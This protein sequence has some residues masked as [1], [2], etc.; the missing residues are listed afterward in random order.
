[1]RTVAWVYFGPVIA[2]GALMLFVF[3][4]AV[5]AVAAQLVGVMLKHARL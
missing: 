3:G 4:F 1:L 2:I 5:L